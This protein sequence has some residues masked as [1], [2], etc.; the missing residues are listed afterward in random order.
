M[1]TIVITSGTQWFVPPDC[2]TATVEAIGAGYGGSASSN[3]G[4]AYAKASLTFTP[5]TYVNINIPAGA[6]GGKTW[7]NTQATTQYTPR[8]VVWSGTQFV[9][10]DN[11]ND[12]IVSPDCINWT[13]KPGG[14]GGFNSPIYSSIAANG[15]NIV[16]CPDYKLDAKVNISNDGGTSWSTVT[17]PVA[18]FLK[19]RVQYVNGVFVITGF[20]NDTTPYISYILTS[21]DNG[22]SWT[23]NLARNNTTTNP[24]RLE[25]YT[26]PLLY[27]SSS[28]LFIGVGGYYDGPGI[29][30][31]QGIGYSTSLGGTQTLIRRNNLGLQAY[32]FISAIA[33]GAGLY[34]VIGSNFI[35]TSPTL[36]PSS[37]WTRRTFS[38]TLD[39][40]SIII[41]D[42]TK[43]IVSV[44]TNG[45]FSSDGYFQVLTSTDGI[46]WSLTKT[47]Q[48][49]TGTISVGSYGDALINTGSGIYLRGGIEISKTTDSGNTWNKIFIGDGSPLSSSTGVIASGGARTPAWQQ[50]GSVYAVGANNFFT[51]GTSGLGDFSCCSPPTFGAGG[52]G[53][54]PNGNGGNGGDY[55]I[56]IGGGGGGANGGANGTFG[57]YTSPYYTSGYGGNNRFGTGG[58][59]GK[60]FLDLAAAID[61]NP[62]TNGGGGGG[63]N[64]GGIPG[65]GSLDVIWTNFTGASYGV[66][67]GGATGT[68]YA[69]MGLSGGPGGAGSGTLGQGIIVITYTSVS[70]PGTY[71]QVF[72]SSQEVYICPGITTF[73]AEAIG[74]GS[75]TLL[76]SSAV[77]SGGGGGAYANSTTSSISS[78][79]AYVNVPTIP[80]P[81]ISTVPANT[82]FNFSANTAPTSSTQ[83]VLAAGALKG[84]GGTV[85]ASIGLSGL[86]FSG[87]N[88]GT[89]VTTSSGSRT[90]GG[91]GGG[92][93]GPNGSGKSG[94]SG[95]ATSS[96]SGGGG[97]GG[98]SNGGSSSS[99]LP[100]ASTNGGNG[101]S[102]SG[103]TAGGTG[104]T[105]TAIAGVGSN[106]S[107]G[108]GGSASTSTST[109]LLFRDGAKGSQQNVYTINGVN[110]GP[111]S[112]GGGAG[113]TSST[114]LSNT[115]GAA[116]GYG[117]G[118]GS[119]GGIT[120]GNTGNV[121]TAGLVVI[122][123]TV[124]A[125]AF[126]SAGNFFMMF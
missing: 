47:S 42:G 120:A 53:A 1:P 3:H 91:G 99:G 92:A 77:S 109:I 108:G 10:L 70:T 81:W 98:G 62:G 45:P 2:Q 25:Y 117:G 11:T 97:G 28:S 106:G 90:K 19:G 79:P 49:V 87:G 67:S 13:K 51:G 6:S 26:G 46:T 115:G 66:G 59:A 35:I 63:G 43:F 80:N 68:Y 113:T 83:G 78:G 56:F 5:G 123:Y 116:G 72:T 111:G 18:N 4:G 57:T 71:K 69:S 107:G 60:A 103:G 40:S 64:F 125:V 7:I 23:I 34:V 20:Y 126:S 93:A 124:G 89:S 14:T 50:S 12:T 33:Y 118:A 27:L 8:Q 84:T 110:Y 75:S 65:S 102:S 54:G 58:G 105:T 24:D 114:T 74:P 61:G 22:A 48:T 9:G 44:Q 29:P 16:V 119:G 88:G 15:S 37:T 73:T 82:W 36:T 95:Y 85:A 104:A 101:G 55:G 30:N 31:N 39:N 100:G 38:T 121:G 112:G 21:T 122:T 86:I 52:G 76:P 94:G 96:L 32:E 41:F 17:L